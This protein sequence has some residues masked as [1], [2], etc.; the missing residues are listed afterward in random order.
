MPLHGARRLP[1]GPHEFSF[2]PPKDGVTFRVMERAQAAKRVA[3]LS[4][5]LRRH[6]YLYYQKNAPQISDA[7]YDRLLAELKDLEALFPEL[8]LPDSPS[9][10]VG[11]PLKSSFAPVRHF[12]P[13]L[14]LESDSELSAAQDFL[15]R[16][17]QAA[18][19]GAGLLAQPKIDGLSVEL[20]FQNGLLHTGSTRGDGA[21]GE[22]ITPNLR[23]ISD[24][25]A[26]LTGRAPDFA[27]VRGEVYMDR[28]GFV[29]LNQSLI[30]MGQ[31]GFANPRNAAAGSLRQL[32]PSVTAGRPLKFF[33]FEL[34]NAAELGLA[35]DS[36]ALDALASWG[37][38]VYGEHVKQGSDWEFVQR[39]H[40][41]YQERRDELP[42]EI[43]GVVFKV[44]DLSLREKLGA[45]SRS[46]RWAFAWKFP[47]R[48]EVTKVRSI[49]V[50][51]GRTGKLTP[52]ALLEPV[53]VSGVTVSRATLHNFGE[54]ER[55]G[56][57]V[58][59]TVRVERAGDV[60]PKVVEV[61]EKGEPRGEAVAAPPRCPVCNSAV[62]Q[63]GAYHLC[64]NTLGCPAQIQAAI[65]HYAGREAMDIEGL[66]PKR[67]AQ[68]ME[69]GLLTDLPSLYS[70]G[71]Q[72]AGLVALKGW[73]ELSADNLLKSIENSR[74]KPLA[75]FLFALGIPTV[76]QATARDIALNLRTFEAVAAAGG[77]ELSRVPGVGPVVAQKIQEFF[78]RPETLAA[79][80][81]LF[82][83]V[84]PA[85]VLE[86]SP[87]A[88]DLPL[89]GKSVVFTGTLESLT[90]GQAEEL[91]RQMGG[92]VMKGVSAA[93]DLV[94]AGVDP[95]SKAD[96]ARELNVE[97][98]G[99]EEF[100]RRLGR[101]R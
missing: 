89:A 101:G 100:L 59:D 64:P 42:F 3:E 94:V 26:H 96:K 44:D 36:Q 85:P 32:D 82:A 79:A 14:S 7:A 25:P 68:L 33:P 99:E 48:Q 55:L 67:V 49:A 39:V 80:R 47:P 38:K 70:L 86:A 34:T 60:I 45:R 23:T 19:Q 8:L 54:V 1:A 29:Q 92:R 97:I 30:Q 98:I 16:L 6:N 81:K 4:A 28:G 9:R 74:S 37:V 73:E 90:R 35:K 56:V 22:D 11:A 58:G 65:R 27:V 69:K 18:A 57:R 83:E 12:R 31:E 46:P 43:D 15:R 20:V 2:I 5:E 84:K 77:E 53:D 66:G 78:A 21:I 40:G 71:E 17:A 75:R 76:G 52:V 91:A 50:Q 72:R 87:E 95:G 62:V 24:I 61:Q 13:M 88:S 10:T 51:V 41:E 63:E 93:T